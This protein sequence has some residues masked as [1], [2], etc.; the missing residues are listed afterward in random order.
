[1]RIPLDL[2]RILGIPQQTTEE[3]IE[4]AYQDRIAQLPRREFSDAAITI[5]NE[6]LAIA[7]DTLSDPENRQAYD[8]QWWGD[9]IQ[10]NDAIPLSQPEFD[11]DP[12]QLIG[13]L[14]I[15]LNLGEYELVL[16]YGEPVVNESPSAITAPECQA[17]YLLCVTLAHWELSRE[18]WQQQHYEL[19]GTASLKAY[20]RL[21]PDNAFPDLQTTIRQDLYKLRPYRILELL[22]Q[23]PEASEDTSQ[24][25][26]QQGLELLQAM[27]Q[28][29]GGIEG[30]GQDHSGLAND[31]FLKF[32]H[33]LRPYL[34]IDEQATVFLPETQR[35]SPIA[36]YLAIH[37]LI[38]QG[39]H[40]KLPPAVL[41][42]KSLAAQLGNCQDLAL[43]NAICGLLLGQT[44]N[45]SLVLDT[46]QETKAIAA[47]NA[48]NKGT[49]DEG[50][51]NS[52]N[53]NVLLAFYQFTESW[54]TR[55][56]LPYFLDLGPDSLSLNAYFDDPFVQD[57]LDHLLDDTPPLD[58][59]P[60]P[61]TSLPSANP[62]TE[63][64]MVHSS[65]AYTDDYHPHAPTTRKGRHQ[66]RSR[67]ELQSGNATHS[68]GNTATLTPLVPSPDTADA[69]GEHYFGELTRPEGYGTPPEDPFNPE[70]N[71]SV[72]L[73][74]RRRRKKRI[75]IKPVR[76]GLFLLCLAGIIGGSAFWLLRGF[77][78][79]PALE[80][81]QLNISLNEGSEFIP[82]TATQN[83]LLLTQTNFTQAVGQQVL[84]SWLD[85]K[86]VAFGDSHDL[87][88][89]NAVLAPG[90]LKQ[91]Q[92]QIKQ[93]IAQN[94]YRQ[95]EHQFKLLNYEVNPQDP[96]QATVIARVQETSQRFP[97]GSTQGIGSPA[98]DDLTVRYQLVRHQ[99]RWKI[100]QIR[101]VT[102]H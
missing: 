82:D 49:D 21:Q 94:Q 73:P 62:E 8:Q 28:D 102:I 89:L 91:Q 29:R 10:D 93:D 69:E 58:F 98:Q 85:Q 48:D 72:L 44:E 71:D 9:D 78:P 95:Y 77:S 2:Y 64:P 31:D 23:P 46:I 76:F 59:P 99:G 37:T 70:L 43:E 36:T 50:D 101:V 35:P 14:L 33:Q 86:K 61:S 5:R 18:Y 79:L 96:S 17:D 88:A 11:C 41:Q 20:A 24:Q 90:L 53:S 75:K 57:Q 3:L 32:I 66:R 19:A 80:G 13:C 15:L 42:A 74:F 65:V 39:I 25:H 97:T 12:R 6:L 56:I 45:L 38:A 100:A 54:L 83:T 4:Q 60:P 55:E 7:Y 81:E 92:Y 30:D 16:E 68:P 34:T 87:A 84:Q 67:Q 51:E 27:I 1:M 22:T 63:T 47:L 40:R 26:R 52:D